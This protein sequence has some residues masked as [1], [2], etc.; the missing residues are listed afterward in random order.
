MLPHLSGSRPPEI[1]I[2]SPGSPITR[3]ICS[4]ASSLA[5]VRNTIRSPLL[6]EENLYTTRFIKKRSPTADRR[7]HR[8]FLHRHCLK[9][10]NTNHRSQYQC[11]NDFKHPAHKA[12]YFFSLPVFLLLP[13]FWD[14]VSSFLYPYSFSHNGITV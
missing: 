1:W 4:A 7:F 8:T 11:H 10:H 5:F 14:F 13:E 9:Q 2:V 12:A 6:G 3:R